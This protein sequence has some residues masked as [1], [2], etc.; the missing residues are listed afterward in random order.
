MVNLRSI[1][2]N[3]LTVLDA[4][5][6]ERHVSRAAARLGMSQPAV[7]NALERCRALFGDP[8]IER[9]GRSMRLTPRGEALAAPLAE[10]VAGIGQLVRP[11]QDTPLAEMRRT[12]RVMAS[13]AVVGI[14]APALGAALQA[15]APGIVA[16]FRPWRSGADAIEALRD[17]DAELALGVADPPPLRDVAVAELGP[18][19]MA[20]LMRRGHPAAA[21]LTLEAWLAWPHVVVSVEGATETG[22]D[23]ML[24]DRGLRR[25]VGLVVPG[26]APAIDALAGSDHLALLPAR[27]AAMRRELV[28]CEPPLAQPPLTVRLFRDRRRLNDRALNFVADVLAKAL[29]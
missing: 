29:G 16:V 18:Q 15:H 14:V 10:L 26:F 11:Q 19:P 25:H 9:F 23:R 22:L 28:A 20:V 17:G 12:I 21:A 7:S 27:F 13:D 1:D 6:A 2:L 8:L 5:L 3:L 24:A 4:V